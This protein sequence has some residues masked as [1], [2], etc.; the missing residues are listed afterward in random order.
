MIIIFTKIQMNTQNKNRINIRTCNI[1]TYDIIFLPNLFHWNT[2]SYQRKSRETSLS[3]FCPRVK[4]Y[5]VP[6]FSIIVWGNWILLLQYLPHV[7]KS[8]IIYILKSLF[9]QLYKFSL[10][11]FLN[12][13]SIVDLLFDLLPLCLFQFS[14]L[15]S[16]N[17]F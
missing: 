9:L 14:V 2:L 6:G 5:F 3:I 15:L 7:L 4:L 1:L 16:S 10:V 11:S 8:Y 13:F 17:S 12:N